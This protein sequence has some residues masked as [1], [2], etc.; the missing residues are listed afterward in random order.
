MNIY[1]YLTFIIATILIRKTDSACTFPDE[2]RGDWY[3][4]HKGILNFNDSLITSYPIQMS[5]IV[6]SLDFTCYEKSGTNYLIKSTIAVIAFGQMIDAYICLDI[7]RVSATK[8][9][10]YIGTTIDNS[11]Q[12]FVKGVMTQT[13]ISITDA[14]NR[15]TPYETNTFITLVKDGEIYTGSAQASCPPDLRAVYSSVVIKN[16]DDSTTCSGNSYDGC[17]LKNTFKSTYEACA[18][19]L[20]FSSSGDFYCLHSET[21]SQVTYTIVWN[22]DTS[23][24]G[25]KYRTTCIAS[26]TV[27]SVLYVTEYPKFC[28]YTN[29]TGT[30]VMSPGIK[31]TMSSQTQTCVVKKEGGQSGFYYFLIVLGILLVAGAVFLGV[32]LY[33]KYRNKIRM[34]ELDVYTKESGSRP[35]TSKEEEKPK[36]T[37]DQTPKLPPIF[38]NKPLI[39]T[40]ETEDSPEPEKPT[41]TVEKIVPENEGEA[42][43]ED[44]ATG[45][46]HCH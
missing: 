44:S 9:M 30:S 42:M 28:M 10:Y 38:P 37:S 32:V 21:V 19:S 5:A 27:G 29:Q 2:L 7:H 40:T 22:N 3:S 24:S 36:K 12:D 31:Y 23:V 34:M 13:N 15:P 39:Q 17:S 8:Y 41:T 6:S 4:S 26:Q 16:S 11:I 46:N 1:I 14:C 35:A 43:N 33:V 20:V 25:T 45:D 18:S